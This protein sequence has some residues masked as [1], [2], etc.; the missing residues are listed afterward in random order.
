MDDLVTAA[1]SGDRRSIARLMSVMER[2]GEEARRALAQFYSRTGQARILGITGAPGTGKSTLVTEM[3]KA[4]RKRGLSVGIVAVDPTS[5][6]SG[7]ALLGD[8]IRMRELATDP[9]VFIRSMATRGSLGGLARATADVVHVLDAT[10]YPIILVETVGAGQSEVDIARTAHTTVVV[11]MPA[12]GD[13]IQAIKAGILEIAD[14]LVVNKA[15][16]PGADSA[17][18]ALRAMLDLNQAHMEW[19]HGRNS[20]PPQGGQM[21]HVEGVAGAPSAQTWRP[22]VLKTCALRGE[23]IEELL[24]AADAHWQYLR[25]SGLNIRR[26]RERVADELRRILRSTLLERL[27]EGIP[28]VDVDATVQNVVARQIDPYSA[29]EAL[30]NKVAPLRPAG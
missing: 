2:G 29:A 20:T 28:E 17:V 15:D 5:P 6:F 12:A 4:Y 16:L 24:T 7:G 25:D 19:H 18:A 22:P 14:I 3:A 21:Q 10:G 8:R 26:D 1:L 30:I 11:E 13:D 27:L 23:G 9:Q